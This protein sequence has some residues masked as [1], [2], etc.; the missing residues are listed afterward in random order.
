MRLE[1][2][3]YD[4]E[5]FSLFSLLRADLVRDNTRELQGNEKFFIVRYLALMDKKRKT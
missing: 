3:A 1:M 2:V 5:I 4:N